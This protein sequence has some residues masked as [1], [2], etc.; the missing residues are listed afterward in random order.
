M[1]S[2]WLDPGKLTSWRLASKSCHP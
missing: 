1:I 2:V